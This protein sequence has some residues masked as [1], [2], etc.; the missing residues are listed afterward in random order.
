MK[1]KGMRSLAVILALGLIAAIAVSL[2][3]CILREPAITE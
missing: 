1:S 2:V 3:T